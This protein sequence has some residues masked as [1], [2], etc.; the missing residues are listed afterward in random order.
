MYKVRIDEEKNRIVVT[1]A[2]ILT[3]SEAVACK[4]IIEKEVVKL[5]PGFDVIDDISNF[6]LGQEKAGP[7]LKEIINYLA[8][9]NVHKIVRVV[10]SS[11]TGL[12]Q[13]AKLTGESKSYNLN[14]VPTL[15]DAESLLGK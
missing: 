3:T 14:Y 10:G 8:N 5:S 15:K 12:I 7:V 9:H 1:L 13:F 6:R 4:E 11:Q 2:G